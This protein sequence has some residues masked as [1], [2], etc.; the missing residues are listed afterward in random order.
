MK[1]NIRKYFNNDY[2]NGLFLMIPPV[3]LAVYL[4]IHFIGIVPGRNGS[5]HIVE[6]PFT[7]LLSLPFILISILFIVLFFT[8]LR[9]RIKL[10]NNGS[11]VTATITDIRYNKDRGALVFTYEF[12]GT[13]YKKWNGIFKNAITTSFK[14]GDFVEV[15][16]NPDKPKQAVIKELII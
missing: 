6:K 13:I 8:R 1:L 2:Y 10:C 14:K 12:N 11:I 3:L 15:L 4:F 16:V 5:N 7:R 9:S